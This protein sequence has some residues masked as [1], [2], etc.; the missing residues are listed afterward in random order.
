MKTLSNMAHFRNHEATRW[1][2]LC[3][4]GCVNQAPSH[5]G[6]AASSPAATATLGRESVAGDRTPGRL[7]SLAASELPKLDELCRQDAS[8]TTTYETTVDE[9]NIPVAVNL[10]KGSGDSA[11]DEAIINL[12]KASHWQSCTAKGAPVQCEVPGTFMLPSSAHRKPKK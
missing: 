4:I 7:L 5:G 11:C 3:L 8:R 12:L 1:L 2:L 10:S 6:S 9:R